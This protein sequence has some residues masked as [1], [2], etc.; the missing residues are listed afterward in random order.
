MLRETK[1]C[2]RA[3]LFRRGKIVMISLVD[4]SLS[5]LINLGLPVILEIMIKDYMFW[6]CAICLGRAI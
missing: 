3:E 2:E 4:V 5:R 6:I 1:D